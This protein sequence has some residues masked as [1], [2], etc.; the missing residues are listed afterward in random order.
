MVSYFR[1]EL[2]R[3]KGRFGQ[4]AETNKFP[5]ARYYTFLKVV[6]NTI[7]NIC[8]RLQATTYMLPRKR[9]TRYLKII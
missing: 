7:I 5:Y 9:Y 2:I 6:Q 8:K 4:D 3:R 1:L